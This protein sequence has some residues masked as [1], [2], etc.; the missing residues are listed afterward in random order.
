VFHVE[1]YSRSGLGSSF[2][3]RDQKDSFHPKLRVGDPD[4]VHSGRL[5]PGGLGYGRACNHDS[6]ARVEIAAACCE[7]RPGG[8]YT[9][10]DH[11]V[12]APFQIR[13]LPDRILRAGLHEPN[14]IEPEL[15][16]DRSE[17]REALSP[18][19]HECGL[20][21]GVDQVERKT[22]DAGARADVDQAKGAGRKLGEKQKRVQE[23]SADDAARVLEPG[24]I[25]HTIPFHEQLEI[26]SEL[27]PVV[28]CGGA[29]GE[30]GDRR[31]QILERIARGPPTGHAF[32]AA[33]AGAFAA[34]AV[35]RSM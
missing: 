26:P 35:P 18:Y 27:P 2:L 31:E 23:E 7:K 4:P 33:R 29:P 8:G 12:R 10:R 20:D 13:L 6:P 22:R 5:W 25:M 34:F 15:T 14:L 1:H 28:H 24:Q 9:S 32:F 21:S 16:A 11:D 3:G 17:E 30:D 19:L